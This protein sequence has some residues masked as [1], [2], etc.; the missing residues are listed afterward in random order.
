MPATAET[1]APV[2]ISTTGRTWW[3]VP[4]ELGLGG[5]DTTIAKYARAKV[6]R[7][8]Y[9]IKKKEFLHSRETGW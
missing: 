2:Y 3:Y 8:R 7:G 4:E 6:S 1:A 5:V 9:S